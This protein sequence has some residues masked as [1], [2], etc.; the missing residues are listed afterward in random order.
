MTHLHANLRYLRQMSGTKQRELA[1][2]IGKDKDYISRIEL[3]KL[4]D[5]DEIWRIALFFNITLDTLINSDLQIKAYKAE[6]AECERIHSLLITYGHCIEVNCR[7]ISP[8]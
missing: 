6:S 8:F 1:D 2:F 5:P 4:K 7:F 3:Q